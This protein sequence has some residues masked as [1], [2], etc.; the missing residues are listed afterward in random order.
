[1]R[2][3]SARTGGPTWERV[4][5]EA[6][7]SYSYRQGTRDLIGMSRFAMRAARKAHLAQNHGM[8]LHF[9]MHGR[10]SLT[11][12]LQNGRRLGRCFGRG[13]DGD[14]D[15]GAVGYLPA[16]R[17]DLALLTVVFL[18]KNGAAGI[19]G[20]DTSHGQRNIPFPI[21]DFDAPSYERRITSHHYH[22]MNSLCGGV[23]G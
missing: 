7:F 1:M 12:A 5:A 18:E 17:F 19:G 2:G 8:N 22:D 21:L 6:S 23:V 14:F 13:A 10:E 15:D 20:Q 16:K 9:N 11:G 3:R 4:S